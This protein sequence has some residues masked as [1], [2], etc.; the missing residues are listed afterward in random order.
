MLARVDDP[1]GTAGVWAWFAAFS[2]SERSS[3]IGPSLNKL[4]PFLNRRAIRAV[5]GQAGPAFELRQVFTERRVLLVNL[6]KG[7]IGPEAA[8]LLGALVFSALWQTALGRSAIP[9]IS[10]TPSW[11]MSTSFRTTCGGCRW[12]SASCWRRP[13]AWAS[14]CTSPTKDCTNSTTRPRSV[15]SD[16]RSRIV[17]QT[18]GGEAK[19]LAAMLGGGLTADDLQA[20]A[21]TRPTPS[22]WGRT[23]DAAS[24]DAH[25]AARGR[26]GPGRPGTSP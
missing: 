13:E 19:T 26:P 11:S 8:R 3:V 12:T 1:L 20:S 22:S 23:S 9:P 2:E 14:A 4:G 5:V 15:L 7:L 24:L 6:A 21:P 25:P 18:A 10:G 16:A 17:F